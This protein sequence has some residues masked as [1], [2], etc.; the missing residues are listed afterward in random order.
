MIA[1]ELLKFTS[2]IAK[3]RIFIRIFGAAQTRIA[4]LA[5]FTSSANMALSGQFSLQIA[6]V[7]YELIHRGAIQAIVNAAYVRIPIH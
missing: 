7:C 1:T 6:Y 3:E 4:P 2:H 5:G